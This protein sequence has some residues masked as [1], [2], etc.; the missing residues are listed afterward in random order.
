MDGIVTVVDAKHVL[1]HL[2]EEKPEG[3]ENEC[4]EQIAFADKII[5]NKVDL[6][7]DYHGS[8]AES[9]K[10]ELI[11]AIKQVNAFAPIVEAQLNNEAV[12]SHD[13]IT[14]VMG[15]G[16]FSL[17]RVLENIDP[18]FLEEESTDHLHDESVSSVGI[19]TP[20]GKKC[21]VDK[22]NNWM[23][24]LLKMRGTDIF[25]CK[26]VLAVQGS[27]F[28]FVFQGIHMIFESHMSEVQVEE[29]FE[30]R[31]IFIGRNLDREELTES[32]NECLA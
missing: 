17:D 6:L 12:N 20:A 1:T 32:F 3:V 14:E 7:E 19:T 29:G 8:G 10:K 9:K 24:K 11:S 21:D 15:I 5:L 22:L 18:N 26:G 28:K 27:E 23:G 13:I 25:R 31:L 2:Y 30:N 16:A 4:H